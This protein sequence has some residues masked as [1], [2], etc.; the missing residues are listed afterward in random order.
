[1]LYVDEPFVPIFR[2]V[3]LLPKPLLRSRAL[4]WNA[5]SGNGPR[6]RLNGIK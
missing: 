4:R 5:A 2:C 3:E 6:S 1:M